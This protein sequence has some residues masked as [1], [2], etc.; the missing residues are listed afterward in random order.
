MFYPE[1][2]GPALQAYAEMCAIIKSKAMKELGLGPDQVI[3][4]P[5]KAT[6]LGF[7]DESGWSLMSTGTAPGAAGWTG[8]NI[9]TQIANG[10]WVGIHGVSTNDSAGRL[11]HIRIQRE[12]SDAR[13]WDVTHLRT[14]EQHTGYADDPVTIDQNTTVTIYT[15]GRTASSLNLTSFLGAVAEKRGMTIN[16]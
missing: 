15:Y 9:V 4:R 2:D 3:L 12:G 11:T 8:S 13:Y 7:A 14:F 5:L 1:L 6:D 16:P 10:R